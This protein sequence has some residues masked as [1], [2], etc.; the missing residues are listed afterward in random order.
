MKLAKR[1][2]MAAICVAG[3]ALPAGAQSV[4]I[5]Y[6]ALSEPLPD[7]T[8]KY[9]SLTVDAGGGSATTKYLKTVKSSGFGG[10]SGNLSVYEAD[11]LVDAHLSIVPSWALYGAWSY[12]PMGGDCVETWTIQPDPSSPYVAIADLTDISDKVVDLGGLDG[13]F[14]AQDGAVLTGELSG[15]YRI[16]VAAGATVTLCNAVVQGEGNEDFK[17]AGITCLGEIGRAH[18]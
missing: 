13:N 7:G 17:W 9:F 16:T 6:S 12:T 3:L 5:T 14:E 2:W 4:S 8:T 15:N 11:S 1:I 10:T 18:V